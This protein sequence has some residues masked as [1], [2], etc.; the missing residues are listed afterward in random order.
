MASVG[1]S[2]A[3]GTGFC[4]SATIEPRLWRNPWKAA[5]YVEMVGHVQQ[6]RLDILMLWFAMAGSD[7]KPDAIFGKFDSSSQFK[8]VQEDLNGTLKDAQALAIGMLEHESGHFTGLSKLGTLTGIDD[9]G[10]LPGLISYLNSTLKFP[11]QAPESMED[12]ELCQIS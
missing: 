11:S 8:S 12:D 1:G 2:C 3:S 5:L 4:G 10:A 7:G 6:I 9:L